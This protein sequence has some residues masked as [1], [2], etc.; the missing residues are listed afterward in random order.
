MSLETTHR[1]M[2]FYTEV[3]ILGVRLV[4]AI[5]ATVV[6]LAAFQEKAKEWKSQACKY[7]FGWW[8]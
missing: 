6:Y 1:L 5:I 3:L 4:L 2:G 8:Y 7:P